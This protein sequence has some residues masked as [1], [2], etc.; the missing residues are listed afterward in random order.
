M[1]K[2]MIKLQQKFAIVDLTFKEIGEIYSTLTKMKVPI[3]KK[4]FEIE[5]SDNPLT[6]NAILYD[7]NRVQFWPFASKKE[8]IKSDFQILDSPLEFIKQFKIVDELNLLNDE[9]MERLSVLEKDN[10]SDGDYI[11]GCE[12]L[13]NN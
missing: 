1:R 2:K 3:W 5:M 10:H 12:L 11:R 4:S 6:T 9:I 7:K 8:L 13:I